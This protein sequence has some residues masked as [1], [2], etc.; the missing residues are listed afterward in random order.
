MSET[1]NQSTNK[2]PFTGK[3]PFQVG[4]TQEERDWRLRIYRRRNIYDHLKQEGRLALL[5]LSSILIA[6]DS[7]GD[8]RNLYEFSNQY[9]VFRTSAMFEHHNRRVNRKVRSLGP[10][11]YGRLEDGYKALMSVVCLSVEN[12]NDEEIV[13]DF[14]QLKLWCYRHGS[15]GSPEVDQV[16]NFLK[17]LTKVCQ[18]LFL[19]ADLPV[20]ESYY[21]MLLGSYTPFRS[22]QLAFIE[23]LVQFC[24]ENNS[25]R[26]SSLDVGQAYTLAQI[27]AGTRT[28]PY[29][30]MH[31]VQNDVLKVVDLI[32][33]P[34]T[35]TRQ[36]LQ[37][38]RGGVHQVYSR[39][40]PYANRETHISLTNSGAYELSRSE[41]GKA[42]YLTLGCHKICDQLLTIEILESITGLFTCLG[43]PI[44]PRASAEAIKLWFKD[45]PTEEI[46]VGNILFSD[47]S[48]LPS[49]LDR[50]KENR[51]IV[52]KHLARILILSSSA[53]VLKFGHYRYNIVPN[54]LNLPLFKEAE[55]NKFIPVIK[56][57]PL[58]ASVSIESAMKSRFITAGPA[59]ITTI[60]QLCNNY[61][62]NFLSRD[63]FVKI[64]FEEPDKFWEVLKQ[65]HNRFSKRKP[66]SKIDLD[67]NQ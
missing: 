15:S 25:T 26:V 10:Q 27:A 31:Q 9:Y 16:C 42:T 41:G 43:E 21:P 12:L 44:L 55:G 17:Y 19:R 63:P 34:K 65:H 39:L 30:S 23:K 13:D 22:G 46:T 28:L 66:I 47:L 7:D 3:I 32:S 48:D 24:Y 56:A 40:G 49:L 29:P 67:L 38:Y 6:K 54:L 5:G 60:G 50:A 8:I 61:M 53:D 45:N 51:E 59:A 36:A 62:R 14:Q 2:S 1:V 57:I 4:L 33:E 20:R 18:A 52:P 64:G 35:I 11:E 37:S 58:T